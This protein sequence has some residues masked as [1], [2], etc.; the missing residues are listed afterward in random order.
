[1]SKVQRILLNSEKEKMT[2]VYKDFAAAALLIAKG[3]CQTFE[4]KPYLSEKSKI[5][6]LKLDASSRVE[7]F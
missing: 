2:I 5:R 3:R 6:D 1:L 7:V 4:A